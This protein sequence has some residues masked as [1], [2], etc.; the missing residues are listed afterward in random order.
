MP[1]K[2]RV[3][4]MTIA[5]FPTSIRYRLPTD[6]NGTSLVVQIEQFE[7]PT[8]RLTDAVTSVAQAAT[9]TISFFE[10]QSTEDLFLNLNIGRLVT[11][12]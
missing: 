11:E 2:Q 5:L 7:I 9:K 12:L 1:S 10:K 8:V 3:R 4:W 6:L